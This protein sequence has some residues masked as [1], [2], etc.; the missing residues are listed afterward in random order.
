MSSSEEKNAHFL[1]FLILGQCDKRKR[2]STT[3]QH[4]ET[5]KN[6]RLDSERIILEQDKLKLHIEKLKS[7]IS[8]NQVKENTFQAIKTMAET[9]NLYYQQ[10]LSINLLDTVSDLS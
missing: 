8:C 9:I 10:K 3:D 1:F 6:T 4:E 7:D 5:L 2:K